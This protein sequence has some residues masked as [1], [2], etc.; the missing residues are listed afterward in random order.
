MQFHPL[1]LRASMALAALCWPAW[2]SAGLSF[3]EATHLAL[4]QAPSLAAQHNA[5]ASAQAAQPAAAT[6]PDPRL[7]LGVDNLPLSGSDR[8]N[9]TRDFMTMQRI[10]LMQEVPNRGKREARAAGA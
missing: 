1:T 7:T 2:A 5:L 4:D 6:L 8:F 10:G 3:D 9:L